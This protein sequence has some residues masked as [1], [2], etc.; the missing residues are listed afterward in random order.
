MSTPAPTGWLV[1]GTGRHADAFGLPGLAGARSA[2]ALAVCGSDPARASA[3]AARHGV[4]G[5]GT[6]LGALLADPEISH[7]YVCSANAGHEQHVAEAA[8]AGKHV[9]CEKPLAPETTGAVR[10][11]EACRR[12]GVVLGTGFHLR[13]NEAHHRARAL[14][15]DG[16]IGVPVAIRVEYLHVLGR[17]DST[18]RLATSRAVTNPSRGSMNGTG[19]HAVDLV[20]W[21]L[22]DEL[23][24]VAARMS[25]K[26]TGAARGPHRVVE[27]T[28]T[29]AR[30]AMVTIAAGRAR[31]PGNGITV[32]GTRGRITVSESIGNHGGGLLRLV[33]DTG[34][35]TVRVEP[36]DVYAAQFDAFVAAT[37][38]GG[39]ASASGA[40]GVAAQR[41]ADAVDHAI[42]EGVS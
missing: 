14:I 27:V 8:A 37:A 24:G 33:S 35:R 22:D 7:V 5:C 31:H 28:A 38:G 11:A 15:R 21:L 9:L 18:A 4:P 40:D 19:S 1:V 23:G 20:R 13:H 17:G 34:E 41:V 36:H 32:L 29:S 2:T 25:E 39:P 16:T 30:G 42:R 3:L 26:D 10:L 12:A 6:A